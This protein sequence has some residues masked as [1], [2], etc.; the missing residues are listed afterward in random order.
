M[1]SNT[2]IMSG[3]SVEFGSMG[4][5]KFQQD[6]NHDGQIGPTINMIEFVGSAGVAEAAGAYVVAPTADIEAALTLEICRRGCDGQT[7]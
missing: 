5:D 4:I 6:L 7:R 2:T 1:F 3:S